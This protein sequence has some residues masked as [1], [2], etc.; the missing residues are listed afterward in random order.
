MTYAYRI[1]LDSCCLNR[2]FDDQTQDRIHLESEAILTMLN[3]CQL[4]LWKLISSDALDLELAKIGNIERHK[5]IQNLLGIAKIRVLQSKEIYSRAK[6]LEHL[7]IM[8]FDA[9]HIASAEQGMADVFLTTDDR[10]HRKA[11]RLGQ[12]LQVVVANPVIWLANI[13]QKEQSND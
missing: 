2:P 7:G 4:G 1:Y 5:Q 13:L 3:F 11:G 10:L 12:Q 8:G 6:V 9:V